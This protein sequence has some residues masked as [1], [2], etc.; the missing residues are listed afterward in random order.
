MIN[1]FSKEAAQKELYLREY[2]RRDFKTFLYLK[3]ERYD[4]KAYYH[5]WHFEYL[6]KV[7]SSTLPKY[8]KD[9]GFPLLRRIILNM[10][11][12]YG[13]TETI[14]RAF[15]AWAL[16]IDPSRKFMYISYS[17]EL[18]KRISNEV[19]DLLKSPYYRSIFKKNPLFLQDNSQEFILKQGGGCFFTTLK[20][21]ITGFHAHSIL[22]DDPIKV[23]EMNSRSAR[24]AV[25]NNFTGS[26][27]SRLKDMNSS[28]IIL[29]QRLGDEDLCGYLLNPRNFSE[30]VIKEWK[31]LKLQAINDKEEIYKIND[32]LYER[33]PKE[34]LLIAR[35]NLEQLEV[36]RLQMGED[37]FSTQYQQEPQA[38]EAGYFEKEY[39]KTILSYELGV[40][41]EYIFVDSATSLNAKADNRAIVV[42]GVER[43]GE[44][45]SYCVK[46]CFFGIWQEEQ[47]IE[48][49]IQALLKYPNSTCYIEK[50]GGGEILHRLLLKE[51]IKVNEELKQKSKAIIKNGIF[52]F[53]ASRKISK[54]DKIKSIRSYYN[55]GY[56]TF[57]KGANGIEQIQKE[58][59]GFNPEKPFRKDDCIDAIATCINHP[60]V[61]APF[62]QEVLPKAGRFSHNATWRI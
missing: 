13:K 62:K 43:K 33:K 10:P 46:D 38:R 2:A 29:M 48:H 12:S 23:S 15:I 22:I 49:L 51:I 4:K 11:P 44:L 45:E 8:C 3:W 32:F 16:G 56:L 52:A 19:R 41:N 24:D 53:N 30:D 9:K 42:I 14:A 34:P 26:V 1:G 40:H 58:L 18:C 28:I 61:K 36:L 57:L 50:E 6:S 37:E 59:L 39:F 54:V 60:D 20:S 55:T 17:D 27:L 21:A 31:I 25:N 5:N 47:S 7:L 35:H